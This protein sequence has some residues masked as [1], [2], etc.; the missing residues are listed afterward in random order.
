M[1]DTVY[2]NK[3]LIRAGHLHPSGNCTHQVRATSTRHISWSQPMTKLSALGTSML[4]YILRQRCRWD[5]A[6]RVTPVCTTR[7]KEKGEKAEN[8]IKA[9]KIKTETR[10]KNKRASQ[11]VPR[12]PWYWLFGAPWIRT[13]WT[14][15]CWPFLPSNFEAVAL[16]NCEYAARQVTGTVVSAS[17]ERTELR[18]A[19]YAEIPCRESIPGVTQP[20]YYPD[21][22]P[23]NFGLFRTMKISSKR[24]VL[25]PWRTPNRKRHH[26]SGRLKKEPAARSSNN[27]K[28]DGADVY[29]GKGLL[30]VKMIR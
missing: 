13:T 7:K 24:N 20:S 22:S 25:Q 18:I 8:G 1:M 21:L 26:N 17:G 19:C 28:I 29:M 27:G 30:Y 2:F 15:C 9:K 12:I 6:H 14:K 11:K 16:Y 3:L 5:N 23:R 4:N 10:N